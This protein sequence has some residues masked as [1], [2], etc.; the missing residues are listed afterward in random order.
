MYKTSN[1]F[2]RIS[3][4]KRIFLVYYT[5]KE[6]LREMFS[7]VQPPKHTQGPLQQWS[8]EAWLLPKLSRNLSFCKPSPILS[9]M[10][11]TR[12]IRSWESRPRIQRKACEP[13]QG[14]L[15]F[16]YS[17]YAPERDSQ[18]CKVD[19]QVAVETP[20]YWKC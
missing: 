3:F 10:Q 15:G 16:H 7:C 5:Y 11:S 8:K 14:V 2:E 12:I 4:E 19:A 17:Q 6:S 13:R 1:W 20:G 18:S 9:G